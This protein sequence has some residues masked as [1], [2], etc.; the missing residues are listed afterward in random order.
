MSRLSKELDQSKKAPVSYRFTDEAL[1]EQ[2]EKVSFC[3]SL[4]FFFTLVDNLQIMS[5]HVMHTTQNVLGKFEEMMTF[6][7]RLRL[8]YPNQNL[9][10]RFSVSQATISR[11]SNNCLYIFCG[12]LNSFI[13]WYRLCP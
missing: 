6:L 9:A 5:G 13:R 1:Q 7:V 8:N 2:D 11:I 10:C 4:A 12:R 3:T